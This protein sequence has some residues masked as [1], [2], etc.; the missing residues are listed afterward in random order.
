[1]ARVFHLLM[2]PR[3]QRI[4]KTIRLTLAYA[5]LVSVLILGLPFPANTAEMEGVEFADEI[6]FSQPIDRTLRLHGMGLLRYRV[7]FKGYVAALYLPE[8]VSGEDALEDVTR[9]L[10]LSYFWSIGA[11]DF[12]NAADRLLE[13]ELTAA[14]LA[15]L[16]LR[17]DALHRAYRDVRPDD[18]Y[19]LTYF[20]GVGTELRLNGELLVLIPGADFARAYFGIWLGPHAL[21]A[22]LRDALLRRGPVS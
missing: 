20:E 5:A 11:E 14:Q 18:R 22:D 3:M 21:D 16:R 19:S 8:D 9:R 6:K 10:E 12:V 7:V 17:I 15:P 4:S 1:M 13:R 2:M